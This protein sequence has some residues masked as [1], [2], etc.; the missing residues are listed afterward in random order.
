MRYIF[1]YFSMNYFKKV[2]IS[3]VLCL[4]NVSVFG[5][6]ISDKLQQNF[7][8]W[9]IGGRFFSFKELVIANRKLIHQFQ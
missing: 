7:L 1:Y 2:L 4:I 3:V 6:E 9:Q 8:A 5:G